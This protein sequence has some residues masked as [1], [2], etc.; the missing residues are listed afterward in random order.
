MGSSSY[1]PHPIPD[2]HDTAL[3]ADLSAPSCS[4][5][6]MQPQQ[7]VFLQLPVSASRAM[8]LHLDVASGPPVPTV[9]SHPHPGT[10]VHPG[11]I[12]SR[13][14][15]RP[16]WPGPMTKPDPSR[17]PVRTQNRR[18]LISISSLPQSENR[19]RTEMLPETQRQDRHPSPGAS[20]SFPSS[21]PCA[22]FLPPESAPPV[23][24]LQSQEPPLS[25]MRN[26]R[27]QRLRKKSLRVG[28]TPSANRT[29]SGGTRVGG[30]R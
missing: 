8:F 18:A 5:L 30:A 17:R 7:P 27:W 22:V 12:S 29:R 19:I 24:A 6:Q 13:F 26:R 21:A 9:V 16:A 23:P 20:K 25:G 15:P 4:F 2:V 10:P 11:R 14:K 28:A 1:T 3:A